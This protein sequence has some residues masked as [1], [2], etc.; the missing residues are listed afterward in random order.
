M[1]HK[2]YLIYKLKGAVRMKHSF[3]KIMCGFLTA[4]MLMTAAPL[5]GFV[6]LKLNFNWLNF[7]TKA[8]A[9]DALAESGTCGTDASYTFD[10][11]TGL[12]TIS[13]TGKI[14]DKMFLGNESIKSVIIEEGITS[15]GNSVFEGC[16]NLTSAIVP[17][18]VSEIG[19]SMFYQC[20]NLISV[21]L[22][23]KIS[24]IGEGMFE[25]CFSL[26]DVTLPEGL[27]SIGRSF[28]F[29]CKKL[30]KINI[31][32]SVTKIDET[33]FYECTNL[34]DIIIPNAVTSIGKSAFSGC[35]SLTNITISANVTS[36]GAYGFSGCSGLSQITVDENNTVYDSREN[37]NAIIET[38][39]NK[40]LFG[41]KNTVIPNDITTIGQDAFSN[42]SGLTSIIIPNSVTY[43]DMYAF[44]GCSGLK[45]LTMPC[46]TNFYKY[47]GTFDKINLKKVTLTKG[48]GTMLDYRLDN[49][50][51]GLISCTNTP[52]YISRNSIEEIILEDGI[53]NIG[54]YA[55]FCVSNLETVVIPESVKTIG[56]CA[57][58]DCENLR[59]ITIPENVTSIGDGAFWS[60]KSLTDITI[61]KN[62]TKIGN[63]L[64]KE[65]SGL[66]SLTI[67][68]GVTDIGESAFYSCSGLTDIT[69]PNSVKNIGMQAFRYCSALTNISIPNN[70]TNI[71]EGTFYGCKS[72]TNITIPE[73]A[74]RIGNE[75]FSF[76]SNL[77][78]I[79]VAESVTNIDM[80][81][82]S[83]CSKLENITIPKGVSSISIGTFYQCTALKEMIIPYTV[84]IV[85]EDA[86]DGCKNLTSLTIYNRNCSLKSNSIGKSTTIYGFSG[87][88]A[89]AYSKSN[90]NSFVSIDE[91]HEHVYDGICDMFCNTC[92]AER[93]TGVHS[94]GEY[95]VTLEPTCTQP[96]EKT[97]ICSLCGY[98][99]KAEIPATGHSYDSCCDKDCNNCAEVRVPPHIDTDDNG[100]CD[101][102]GAFLS[103]IELS[104]TKNIT[105]GN[106]ETVYIKFTAPYT[107]RYKFYSL[108]NLDT[109]GYICDADKNPIASDDDSGDGN[110]FSVI[111]T[112][113][114]GTKY[115]LGAKF[116]NSSASGTLPVKIEYICD[117]TSTHTEHKD[118]TC[119]EQGY[120]KKICDSCGAIL[121]SSVLPFSHNYISTVTPPTCTKKGYTVYVC[122]ICGDN[123]VSDYTNALNH[124]IKSWSTVK[125]PTT[126]STGLMIETCELCGTIFR[127]AVMPKLLPDFVTGIT[128]SQDKVALSVGETATLTAEVAPDTAKNKNI[129]W[130]SKDASV[131]G[132]ENG[133]ITAKEP[134][135]TI[136]V[137][138]TEDGGYKDFCIVR[139]ASLTAKNGAVV[140]NENGVIY[141]FAVRP[142]SIEQYIETVDDSMTVQCDSAV[143]GTG[144]AVNVT[145]NGETVDSFKIV[146]F[147]DVDGDGIYDGQDATTVNLIAHGMLTREQ[148]G[149]AVWMAAD[150]NHDGVID[151]L[152]VNLLNRAGLLLSK[153]DQSKTDEE[154]STDSA[155]TEYLS[156][157]DQRPNEPDSTQTDNIFLK[158][159]EIIKLII[160]FIE[161][162]ISKG[163]VL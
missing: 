154:L 93:T 89:E 102:C 16:T 152:D 14:S 105:V 29:R 109:Y 43:I 101:K 60:C 77:T 110:N 53:E 85:N 163:F 116:Y 36:I 123:Y 132:V 11:E 33:A 5:S 158:I 83:C 62:I 128:L 129:I 65:C 146:I 66:K 10:A 112:L 136:I 48:S 157:I 6:G 56:K 59:N 148:V 118:S 8:A 18:S 144:S 108:S 69:I 120:D 159:V 4:V 140:D 122:S 97:R 162:Y 149:E 30:E 42:C 38:A 127:E 131:A 94:Y 21:V 121:S 70:I 106:N 72:L 126:T 46:S 64:F 51:N 58:R 23:D 124:P 91:T 26:T 160:K 130:S 117:H 133:V 27:T 151:N 32:E 25:E 141:G 107:G 34:S 134:G 22:P 88:T 37:C 139:V 50:G 17:N 138:Q 24:V 71:E 55:F 61:P 45:E 12:L 80:Y 137:A 90:G 49:G 113:T 125:N 82:F 119:T 44:Y 161:E 81:A 31:P 20:K 1:V 57:F 79:T 135:V 92:G 13:G 99:E 73:G 15:V 86:F 2:N 153:V 54:S 47:P 75:A 87:S 68:D 52:W 28:F 63:N 41:C 111:A 147:G 40:L 145:K 9:A 39:T 103:D 76:C 115:Y 96:G 100:L 156:L 98:V 35:K 7:G 78:S 150:C 74:I 104:V 143:I 19:Y 84:N 155:Y 114:K 3:K 67:P 95:T 142:D